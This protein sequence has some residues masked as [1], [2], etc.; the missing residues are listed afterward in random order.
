MKYT[1]HLASAA[2]CVL[3]VLPL[4]ARGQDIS[5]AILP[6]GTLTTVAQAARTTPLIGQEVVT[7]AS[8]S[9]LY[10]IIDRSTDTAIEEELKNAESFRNFDSK[11]QLSTTSQLNA[12]VLLIGVVEEQKIER[13]NPEKRGEEPSYT[14]Q[15][16]IRVKLVNTST[17][18]LI[19]SAY[20]EVRNQTAASAVAS[21]NRFTKMLPKSVREELE[22]KLDETVADAADRQDVDMKARSPE[23]AVRRASKM[24]EA[25]LKEFLENSF[26]A[27]MASRRSR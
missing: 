13:Q 24:L 6:F 21:K 12:A 25:P 5:L 2:L 10:A 16:G 20:F 9:G 18:Q 27:V 19:K 17:G 1:R 3:A 15:L 8:E 14:A 4:D 11:V 22:K 26:G 7:I 23:E